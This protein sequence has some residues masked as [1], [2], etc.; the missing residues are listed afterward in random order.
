LN[1]IIVLFID[2]FIG[3]NHIEVPNIT[4]NSYNNISKILNIYNIAGWENMALDSLDFMINLI[5]SKLEIYQNL[6]INIAVNL[7]FNRS[8]ILG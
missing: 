3:F 4:I 6:N 8:I 7:S 2:L 1:N 5:I